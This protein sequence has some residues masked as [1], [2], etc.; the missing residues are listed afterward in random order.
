MLAIGMDICPVTSSSAVPE[1]QHPPIFILHQK[2]IFS[3]LSEYSEI[4]PIL[5]NGK[6]RYILNSFLIILGYTIHKCKIC[7]ILK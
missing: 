5:I 3:Y 1:E 6:S 4:F 7:K 2:N